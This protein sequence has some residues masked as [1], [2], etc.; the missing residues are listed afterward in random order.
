MKKID[1]KYI[2]KKL[3]ISEK[4]LQDNII[5]KI[6]D[7]EYEILSGEAKNDLMFSIAKDI[8]EAKFRI[9]G[10]NNSTV[11][12]KGWGEVFEKIKDLK[13]F[14]INSLK[15]QYVDKHNLIRID[16]EYAIA[17]SKDL[18]FNY[19]ITL[20]KAIF[21]KYLSGVKKIVEFGAGTGTTQ[22]ILTD[23]FKDK[24][25]ELTATDW[26]KPALKIINLISEK[27]NYNISTKILNMLDL[28]GWNEVSIDK[29]TAIITIH[30]MEQLGGNFNKLLDNIV[31]AKPKFCLHLEPMNEVYDTNDLSDYLAHKYHKKRNYLDGFYTKL[32]D[33]ESKNVIKINEF[34]RLK[35]GDRYHETYNILQWEVL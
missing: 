6:P 2:S 32:K 29:N 24:N 19:D 4:E 35:F 28:E 25:V 15:P 9:V 18:M 27:L 22:M 16:G 33:L 21:Y 23:L 1:Q 8:H 20:R 30:A 10:D 13:D 14:N 26:S 3:D 31:K 5:K 17:K 34:K 11:W 7:M 12:Q